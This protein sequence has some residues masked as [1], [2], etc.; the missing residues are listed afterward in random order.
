[1]AEMQVNTEAMFHSLLRLQDTH[2]YYSDKR[3]YV[4]GLRSDMGRDWS[5]ETA[6]SFHRLMD[7]WDVHF[8]AVLDALSNVIVKLEANTQGYVDADQSNEEILQSFSSQIN[9]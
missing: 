4:L 3:A 7:Q 1:M 2:S 8:V 9:D 5:G 6:N